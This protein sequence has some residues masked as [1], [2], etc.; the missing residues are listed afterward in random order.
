MRL[1]IKSI[2]FLLWVSITGFAA[3][4]NYIKDKSSPGIVTEFERISPKIFFNKTSYIALDGLPN[5]IISIRAIA[6]S[7]YHSQ[8]DVNQTKTNV[9]LIIRCYDDK[10]KRNWSYRQS[11]MLNPDSTVAVFPSQFGQNIHSPITD[12]IIGKADNAIRSIIES[13]N[14]K[15]LRQLTNLQPAVNQQEDKYLFWLITFINPNKQ[16]NYISY[17]RNPF[18]SQHREIIYAIDAMERVKDGKYAI[19]SGLLQPGDSVYVSIG[20]SRSPLYNSVIKFIDLRNP[21]DNRH[22]VIATNDTLRIE[23]WLNPNDKRLANIAKE[24]GTKLSKRL[25]AMKER[26]KLDDEE[27]YEYRYWTDLMII[28]A[29]Q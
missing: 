25:A 7:E 10:L 8:N 17:S 23:A 16:T 24:Y 6:V 13:R 21:D 4:A 5:N 19:K 22:S 27:A 15:F 9:D 1:H 18:T 28:P 29:K 26:A 14:F 2:L 20:I 11:I 3:Y 12:T